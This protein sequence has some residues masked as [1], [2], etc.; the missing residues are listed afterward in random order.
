[1]PTVINTNLASLYAQNNLANAQNNLALSVQ[2]LSSGLRINSAKDD[3]A[4]L[5]ISQSMQSQILGLDMSRRNLNDAT[6]LVQVA[7]TAMSTVQDMLLRMKQLSSQGLNGSMGNA[8]VDLLH[9]IQVLNEQINN[10]AASTKFNG[11]ELVN[12]AKVA[13]TGPKVDPTGDVI[14]GATLI[15]P[16]VGAE[17]AVTIV[18]ID[19]SDSVNSTDEYDFTSTVDGK[20]TLTRVSGAGEDDDQTLN[21]TGIANL[22]P[23]EDQYT[24]NF[25]E[26]GIKVTVAVGA[27]TDNG[28]EITDALAGNTLK[29]TRVGVTPPPTIDISGELNN[30]TIGDDDLATIINIDLS[31]AP[32]ADDTF[33]LTS[34][35]SGKFTLTSTN[36]PDFK[37]VLDLAGL[38]SIEVG[39]TFEMNFDMLG[40]KITIANTD[41]D[42]NI[43]HTAIDLANDIKASGDTI[44]TSV[45]AEPTPGTSTGQDITFQAG[46]ETGLEYLVKYSTINTRTDAAGD[47]VAG[48]T[49]MTDLGS[50]LSSL[51]SAIDGGDSIT[52]SSAF[53]FFGAAVDAAINQTSDDRSVMGALMNRI[54]YISTNLAA[55]STNMQSA[56]S[57][58][59]D[60]DFAA[61]TA[62][63]TK[64]QIMQQA[65]TAMLAQA[66]QM[67]NVVLSL[68]K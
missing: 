23:F 37:Q 1:M 22:T 65:A 53:R 46:P 64:G 55:Q 2:R 51:Q 54:S 19:L 30:L 9:E 45:T 56:R 67:P 8:R 24:L 39:N 18:N 44:K 28:Y 57:S 59:I 36:D 34:D 21:L 41:Q 60:T 58:I 3:A 33:T 27:E 49:A 12:S 31:G 38:S 52:I 25:D 29:T 7:D 68:L 63:L 62:R 20:I 35:V 14:V 26:L 13:V 11:V 16:G 48:H 4:G 10:T 15:A 66:N 43:A 61:E 40:I 42:G 5:S 17:G 32:N 6:S 47:F 50:A